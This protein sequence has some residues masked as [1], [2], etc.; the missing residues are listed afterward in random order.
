M[1]YEEV[2][3]EWS[4]E[5]IQVRKE[6]QMEKPCSWRH[7]TS[8]VIDC[9]FVKIIDCNFLRFWYRKKDHIFLIT[10]GEVY[11]WQM[12]H[13]EDINENMTSLGNCHVQ[14]WDSN[15]LALSKWTICHLWS[16]LWITDLLDQISYWFTL[17]CSLLVSNWCENQRQ[18]LSKCPHRGPHLVAI[19]SLGQHPTLIQLSS[20]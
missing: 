14:R 15:F 11:S 19:L 7:G 20:P 18:W 2:C 13:L 4:L 9:Q 10:P 6:L 17:N 12:Y 1:F 5:P 3:L 8:A 16:N